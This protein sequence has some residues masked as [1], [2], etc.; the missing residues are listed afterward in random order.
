[1]LIIIGLLISVVI[2]VFFTIL[3]F[4]IVELCKSAG[5]PSD[6]SSTPSK[7]GNKD[8]FYFTSEELGNWAE[9]GK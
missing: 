7:S 2:G 3:P 6:I 4:F 1:M 8:K 9:T 5:Y